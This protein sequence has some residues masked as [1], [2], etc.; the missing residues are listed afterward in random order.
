MTIRGFDFESFS[1]TRKSYFHLAPIDQPQ[2]LKG[3]AN[4][5]AQIQ[6]NLDTEG[7]Q[8]F[9]FGDRGVGKTSLARTAA[10]ALPGVKIDPVYVACDRQGSFFQ[11]AAAM[12][13]ELVGRM[14][15]SS[16]NSSKTKVSIL[17]KVLGY[18]KER[19]TSRIYPEFDSLSRFI[20]ALKAITESE[21]KA[22]LIIIDELERFENSQ[23]RGLMADFVKRV[24][25]ER[26]NVKLVLCGIASSIS[27]LIG[28]HPSSERSFS[29]IH[30]KQLPYDNLQEIILS[31]SKAFSV[32]VPE[33]VAQ[34]ISVISD[35]FP[36]FTQLIGEQLFWIIFEDEETIDQC[37]EG[38]FQLAIDRSVEEANFTLREKYDR[39]TLKYKNTEDFKQVLWSMV[40]SPTLSRQVADVYES[41]YLDVARIMKPE[42]RLSPH[43]FNSR[44]WYLTQESHGSVLA[45]R[46]NGWYEFSER[47][48]RGYV[49]LMAQAGGLKFKPDIHSSDFSG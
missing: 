21:P 30:L 1:S 36:Y 18:E 14:D 2:H 7:R 11:M 20:Q 26:I 41:S 19:E 38:H 28:D 33:G 6:R 46:G 22:P 8:I 5:I 37:T 15:Q 12:I 45:S 17:A 43:E 13:D 29:P 34:R 48:M 25:D 16:E 3:R 35:G 23:D 32:E 10:F 27:G 40:L 31:A 4:Q 42:K 39:A 24:S 49:R 44:V 47:M 9:I